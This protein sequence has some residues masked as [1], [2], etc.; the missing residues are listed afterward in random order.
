MNNREQIKRDRGNEVR[1]AQGSICKTSVNLDRL[2]CPSVHSKASS[3]D[4]GGIKEL[5]KRQEISR[6]IHLAIERCR[7][8][9]KNQLK[10]ST[11]RLGI[12]R[13][14]VGVEIA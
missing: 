12:E 14:R 11:D 9:D 10:I 13:C 3:M 5:L 2:R 8:C 7:D 6:L 1:I 4:Q